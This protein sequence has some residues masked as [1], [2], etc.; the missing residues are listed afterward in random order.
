MKIKRKALP[1]W[2]ALYSRARNEKKLHL[3]LA[4]QSIE[5]FLPLVRTLKQWSDRKKWVEEPMIRSYVFVRIT[6]REY[7]TVLNTPGA[8]RYVFFEGRPAEIPNWQIEALKK[9]VEVG[10]DFEISNEQFDPGDR[11]LI[12][13]GPFRG[14][15]GELVEAKG[16]RKVVVR[17]EHTGYNLL[18]TIPPGY[19][20]NI[21]T[22]AQADRS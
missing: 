4:K 8:V 5:S 14:I 13:K 6:E 20:K 19:L 22:A 7:F 16:K 11:I 3:L 2:Y 12:A 9:A 17:I 15:E 1:V 18:L 21:T 10:K